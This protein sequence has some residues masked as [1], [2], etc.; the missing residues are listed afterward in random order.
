[1]GM[2]HKVGSME[3]GAVLQG[4]PIVLRDHLGAQNAGNRAQFLAAFAQHAIVNDAQR[5]FCGS[6]AIGVWAEREIFGAS[7]TVEIEQAR[8]HYSNIILQ[9]RVDGTFDKSELP[10]PLVLHYYYTITEGK[11]TQVIIIRNKSVA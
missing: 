8:E 9:C 2:C 1:M 4:L 5:E 11:I 10:D 6:E 7:V 3:R